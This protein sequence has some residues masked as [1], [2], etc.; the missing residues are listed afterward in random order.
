[1]EVLRDG[2]RQTITARSGTRP[3]ETELNSENGLGQGGAAPNDP[4]GASATVEG[5]NLTPLTPAL[6]QRLGAPASVEG[7]AIMGVE[8]G[9]DARLGQGVVIQQVQNT[10]VRTVD[11]FRDAVASVKASG[12]SGAYLLIWVRG[13]GNVPMC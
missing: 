7:L 11:D 3:S 12:R 6:R 9:V 13:Q 4:S 8:T 5:L 1:M 2:R 10:P